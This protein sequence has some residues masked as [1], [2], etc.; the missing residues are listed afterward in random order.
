MTMSIISDGHL[1]S[2]DLGTA[3]AARVLKHRKANPATLMS[4]F[5]SA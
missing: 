1:H 4:E 3:T 2:V 5:Y